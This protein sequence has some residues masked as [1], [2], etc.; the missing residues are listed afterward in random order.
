MIASECGDKPGF[1]LPAEALEEI[2]QATGG[3]VFHMSD[4]PWWDWD[5]DQQQW[6]WSRAA[7]V[8]QQSGNGSGS[9]PKKL[10]K[11]VTSSTQN[12]GV[13]LF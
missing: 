12:P 6:G 8:S 4:N 2:K 11:K 5:E 10:R 3:P 9:H 13:W 7:P 1:K